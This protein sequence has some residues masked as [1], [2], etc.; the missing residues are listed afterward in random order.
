[1]DPDALQKALGMLRQWLENKE[2]DK[3]IR[4]SREILL[5]APD[6]QEA[7]DL[8][9]KAE[10]MKHS[11]VSSPDMD[12]LKNLQIEEEKKPSEFPNMNAWDNEEA[13]E[14]ELPKSTRRGVL[15]LA[16]V[17]PMLIVIGV[18]GAML[19]L[20]KD[21]QESDEKEAIEEITDKGQKDAESK[22]SEAYLEENEERIEMMNEMA[23]ILEDYHEENG[24]YPGISQV[25]SILMDQANW[26]EFPLDPKQDE[27]D[28][29]GK[30][31]G[32]VYAVY[33]SPDGEENAEYILS[34]LFEDSDGYGYAWSQGSSSRNYED[35]RDLELQNVLLLGSEE[36]DE[37]EPENSEAK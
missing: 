4:G 2:Y 14:D 27:V 3:V 9:K 36:N 35:F 8:L 20:Y 18:G 24:A 30:A 1:M 21:S 13:S 33:E 5:R 26:E 15:F 34:A 23:E 19:W 6:N 31:F 28:R 10:E 12:P 7:L 16:T 22:A 29:T 32:Y 37:D 17:I 25:E 11:Q